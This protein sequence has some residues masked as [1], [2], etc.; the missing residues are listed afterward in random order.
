MTVELPLVAPSAVVEE[1][2]AAEEVSQGTNQ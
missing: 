2:P 1:V